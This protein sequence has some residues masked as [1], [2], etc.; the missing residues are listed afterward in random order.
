MNEK[1]KAENVA[2]S[3]QAALLAEALQAA[4][5]HDRYWLNTRMNIAPAIFN[6]RSQVSPFNQLTMAADA[7]L[8]GYGTNQYITYKNAEALGMPVRPG[9]HGIPFNWYIWDH[10]VNRHDPE[11]IISRED[12]LKLDDRDKSLYK[13]V[14]HREIRHMYNID[15][16]SMPARDRTR[17]DAALKKSGSVPQG[18]ELHKAVKTFTGRMDSNL[19][20]IRR[21]GSDRAV[22]SSEKDAIYMPD[23]KRFEH[24]TD[25]VQELMR[26]TVSATGHGERL[27]RE[28]SARSGGTM[29][30]RDAA[31]QERL[32]I[33]LASAV[34]M[35]E[36]GQA[37]RLAPESM[38]MV[39]YWARELREDPTLID[40]V[41]SDVNNALEVIRKAE[42]GEHIYYTSAVNSTLTG[43]YR[44]QQPKHYY[45]A[46]AISR[47]PDMDSRTVAIIRDR[48]EGHADVILPDG[49]SPKAEDE[50]SGMSKQRL[51]TALAKEGFRS[52]TFF[53]PDGHFRYRP[54]DWQFKDKEVTRSRLKGWTLEDQT[55]V[56]LSIPLERIGRP[57]FDS[58]QFV[59]DEKGRW[60]VLIR[61]ENEKGYAMYMD[62]ADVNSLFT[63]FHSEPQAFADAKL[64]MAAKYHALAG[65]HPELKT[66]PGHI[67]IEKSMESRITRVYVYR[68][69]EKQFFIAADIDG[70]EKV[71]PREISQDFWRRLWWS[72]DR[73]A[74]KKS[75]AA[76]TFADIL[77]PQQEQK[78]TL[79]NGESEK[80]G[81]SMRL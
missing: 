58:V 2:A 23:Q 54:D 22:Y 5:G 20:S 1:T 46:D 77:R 41:E 26:Q 18:I 31:R 65:A 59:P 16:T 21:T 55:P 69:A 48:K 38:E 49:A 62:K 68:T 14:R 45:I 29:P 35:M 4:A 10:Y 64:E 42:R 72:E 32:I 33:E 40:I 30:R 81:H 79:E 13:G 9:Q 51:R 80:V 3:R 8:K 19:V 15:Q 73:D 27:A 63:K 7:T 53:N 60:M 28:T 37:A 6:N 52:V 78:E 76:L 11:D 39:D 24:Y 66:D 75:L 50:V 56:E 44:E 36:L 71:K 47:L 43:Q 61:P 70:M 17:Y 12:Y 34:K 25:Y 67:D 74:Y 57:V